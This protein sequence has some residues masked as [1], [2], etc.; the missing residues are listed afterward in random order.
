LEKSEMKASRINYASHKRPKLITGEKEYEIA[1][2]TEMGVKFYKEG[3]LRVGN[4]ILGTVALLCGETVD[5][6]G[7]I[8][9][10]DSILIHMN[11]NMPIEKVV[12][13]KELAFLHNNFDEGSGEK[14]DGFLQR[15]QNKSK[16]V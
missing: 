3:D 2:I 14:N 10:K 8:V 6:E 11:V 7:M 1:L 15:G 13:N 12:L 5:I 9:G 4:R 16:R